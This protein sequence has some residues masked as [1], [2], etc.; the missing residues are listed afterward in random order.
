MY[1]PINNIAVN[2]FM[3]WPALSSL[4]VTIGGMF[5]GTVIG[6]IAAWIA[7]VGLGAYV[8]TK[9][10]NKQLCNCE[11]H[12]RKAGLAAKPKLRWVVEFDDTSNTQKPWE[13]YSMLGDDEYTKQHYASYS[14]EE[15]ALA[16]KEIMENMT[17]QDEKEGH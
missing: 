3:R 2:T 4:A 12:N 1:T 8:A 6:L 10:F 14:T 13:L 16:R 17:D 9:V 15:H 5:S 7:S 11:E